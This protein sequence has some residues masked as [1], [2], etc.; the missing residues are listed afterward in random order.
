MKAGAHG[1]EVSALAYQIGGEGLFEFD[2]G[3][4]RGDFRKKVKGRSEKGSRA[5]GSFALRWT[6]IEDRIAHG[7]SVGVTGIQEEAFV[8]LIWHQV[9]S[10]SGFVRGD[11]LGDGSGATAPTV[12]PS[13]G[14]Q[15]RVLQSDGASYFM[16]GS[17]IVRFTANRDGGDGW[18]LRDQPGNLLDEFRIWRVEHLTG[19]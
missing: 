1:V 18:K 5:P 15:G 10:R 8:V 2:L 11:H 19:R 7:Q 6:H 9:D 4:G 17:I 3:F 13:A 16:T 14:T 12:A